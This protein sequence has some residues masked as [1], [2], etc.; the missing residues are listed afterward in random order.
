VRAQYRQTT[1]ERLL[2]PQEAAD[3]LAISKASVY[4]LH[5]QG[6]LR[7]VHVTDRSIRFTPDEIRRYIEER[8][9]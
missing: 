9:S 3:L 2:R 7:G 6:A 4:R 8:M 5:A 1:L